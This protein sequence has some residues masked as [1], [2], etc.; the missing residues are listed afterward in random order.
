MQKDRLLKYRLTGGWGTLCKFLGHEI[1][2]MPFPRIN[3]RAESTERNVVIRKRAMLRF[4]KRSLPVLAALAAVYL[5]RRFQVL[6]SEPA[7]FKY[8]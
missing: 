2:H 8:S 7:D 5:P 3:E 1:P 6:G 4:A